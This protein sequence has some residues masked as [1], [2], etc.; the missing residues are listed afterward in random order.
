MGFLGN[1]LMPIAL[2]VVD[3]WIKKNVSDPAFLAKWSNMMQGIQAK[4]W[5]SGTTP[6]DYEAAGKPKPEGPKV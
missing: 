6:S 5:I 2:N 1:L 4:E 3:R